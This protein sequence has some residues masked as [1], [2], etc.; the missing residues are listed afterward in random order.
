MEFD[1]RLIFFLGYSRLVSPLYILHS[2]PGL[3]VPVSRPSMTSLTLTTSLP[4]SLPT[5]HYYHYC[6]HRIRITPF[7]HRAHIHIHIPHPTSTFTCIPPWT[8][9]PAQY[10]CRCGAIRTPIIRPPSVSCVFCH[11]TFYVRC[12]IM[13]TVASVRLS[14]VASPSLVPSSPEHI[15]ASVLRCGASTGRCA[16]LY[17]HIRAYTHPC[18]WFTRSRPTLGLA[19][20]VRGGEVD[21][22]IARSHDRVAS[23]HWDARSARSVRLVL[24][25]SG[26]GCEMW[27]KRGEEVGWTRGSGPGLGDVRVRVLAI[28]V[29]LSLFTRTSEDRRGRGTCL[30]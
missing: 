26:M 18:S 13:C 10:I 9:I 3:R 20:C 7:S 4:T 22:V 5:E 8:L 16:S 1:V 17:I 25:S 15:D 14:S 12:I 19:C 2:C 23:L 28:D 24:G 21:R 30:W 29:S 27:R 11:T 6:Y